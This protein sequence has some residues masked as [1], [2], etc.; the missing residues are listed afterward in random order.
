MEVDAYADSSFLVSLLRVDSNHE[1]AMRYM[2]ECGETLAFNP[3]HRVEL[4][5]A[6][7][8]AQ[9]F[10]QITENERRLAFRRIEQDLQA[11]LL[12]YTRVSWTDVFRLADEL[13]D[14]HSGKGGQRTIA[15]L[16]V[17]LAL[18]C[19]AKTFLSFDRR[20]RSLAKAAN[21]IVKP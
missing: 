8:N 11:R 5:N 6:L 20:Q 18:E 15:L 9:A 16:H 2:A 7:R 19:G 14:K 17:A 1:A 21:L 4:R 13:S 10:G 12:I 3:L